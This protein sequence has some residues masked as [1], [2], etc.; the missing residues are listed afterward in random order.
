VGGGILSA[1]LRSRLGRLTKPGLILRTDSQ[2]TV[3]QRVT[4]L[5]LASLR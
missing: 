5:A 2:R 3:S 1:A 4:S